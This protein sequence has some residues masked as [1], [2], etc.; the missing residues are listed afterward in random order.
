MFS[1]LGDAPVEKKIR[2]AINLYKNK[3]GTLPSFCIINPTY[4]DISFP[5]IEII[6]NRHVMPNNFWLGEK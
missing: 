5:D 2:Q 6:L 1:I 4:G 3:M